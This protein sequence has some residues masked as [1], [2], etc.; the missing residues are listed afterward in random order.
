MPAQRAIRKAPAL[1]LAAGWALGA[2]A[3]A[4]EARDERPLVVHE[5]GTFTSLQDESG[6]A[7]GGINSDDEPLPLW[8]HNLA[9]MLIIGTPV[10]GA[11]KC[12][13]DVTLRLETPVIYFHPPASAPLPVVATVRAR[14]RGGWLTQYYPDARADAPG[15]GSGTFAF[16]PITR[17]TVGELCWNGLRI[18][19][20]AAGRQATEHVWLAPRRVA[21]ASVTTASGESERFLFYRGVGHADAPLRVSS[22]KSD[23]ARLVIEGQLGSSLAAADGRARDAFLAQ[24]LK[25]RHLWLLEVQDGGASAYAA[26]EPL[27]V[28]EGARLQVRASRFP[29]GS[30]GQGNLAGL[31]AEMHRVLVEEG[32][33]ADEAAALLS[34]W[35]LSYFK[36]PGL[37][38]FFMVPRAWTDAVLPLDLS[39]PADVTRVMIGRIELVTPEQRSLL[40]RLAALPPSGSDPRVGEE[41]RGIVRK[42]GRFSDAL[43][44]DD[45]KRRSRQP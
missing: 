7:I 12:H 6:E 20:S 28:S 17:D 33:F 42:L 14:F 34:T 30:F 3:T 23:P 19:G 16:G 24:G 5:W 8:T 29:A 39:V 44:I 22:A 9:P 35:E 40:G 31:R 45:A 21:A 15:L 32:L 18:G 41:Q 27:E 13:P 10:Q 25:A 4:A 2:V 37:R 36:S 43:I 26:L 1:V 38:L 11:P